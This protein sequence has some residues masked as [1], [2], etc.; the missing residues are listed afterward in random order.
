MSVFTGSETLIS[1]TNWTLASECVV[2]SHWPSPHVDTSCNLYGAMLQ[3]GP[4]RR[5][6]AAHFL[7]QGLS[8]LDHETRTWPFFHLEKILIVWTDDTDRTDRVSQ[9]MVIEALEQ[10]RQIVFLIDVGDHVTS[11][12]HGLRS[13][14]DIVSSPTWFRPQTWDYVL[15]KILLWSTSKRSETGGSPLLLAYCSPSRHGMH[16]VR[17]KDRR[18]GATVDFTFDADGFGGE[19]NRFDPPWPPSAHTSVADCT[20]VLV[21]PLTTGL[22]Q[23][24]WIIGVTCSLVVFAYLSLLLWC[25]KRP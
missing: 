9:D 4:L 21:S 22:S 18:S 6:L 13:G 20:K 1:W 2:P 17:V 5:L 11:A 10:Q 24:D 3:V 8:V 12:A 25:V 7:T 16:K 15:D 23:R 19:C 14:L